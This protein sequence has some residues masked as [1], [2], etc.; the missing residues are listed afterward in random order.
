MIGEVD[1]A[2]LLSP[3]DVNVIRRYVQTKY[4]PLSGAQRADIVA[5]AIRQTIGRRLPDLSEELKGRIADELIRR[6]LVSERR[7]IRPDDVLDVCA[8]IE[9]P[10]PS[11]E[12]ELLDPILRWM[13][14]RAPGQWSEET[15][16]A[17]LSRRAGVISETIGKSITNDVT[18][19]T[20]A[21]AADADSGPLVRGSPWKRIPQ[22][23][24]ALAMLALIGGVA[25]GLTVERPADSPPAVLSSPPSAA[26]MQPDRDI[27]M[28]RML[29][30]RDIDAKAVK[31]FLNGRDSILADEPYFSAI[32][33]G[34]RAHDVN[35]LLLFAITGQEQG[36]VPKSGKNAKKIANNP[37][38]V[39]H[40]WE[41]FNTTI[42]H[43]AE[44]AARTVSRQ[45][46]KRPEGRDPFEWLN[47]TYAEDPNWATGVSLIFSKLSA[48]GS[49]EKP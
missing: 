36:F 14:E 35:P 25:V 2:A 4:A 47:Q 10:D 38:N 28:P 27:G 45:G 32:V 15:L 5:T 7:A 18:L 9:L 16:V 40:S 34:A 30:Y 3:S 37:F 29:R 21:S 19:L 24:W 13:N 6:C 48:L 42:G 8:E 17:R 49:N 22:A 39:F 1:N 41:E 26:P 33:D 31:A 20:E 23:A 43:S 44:I 11:A 46:Q 12:Y